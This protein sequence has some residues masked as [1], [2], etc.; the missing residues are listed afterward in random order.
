[1]DNKKILIYAEL[2]Q[3]E[4]QP[5][6]LELMTKARDLF[7]AED[8]QIAYVTC[9]SDVKGAVKELSKMGADKVYYAQ[10]EKLS[11][12]NV[13]YYSAVI[14]AVIDEFHPDIVLIPAS[15][16]G[17][18][19]SPTISVQCMTAGAAHCV[20]LKV[21]ED[22]QFVTMVPAFGGK[23][24]GEIMI[25]KTRP[26]IASIKPGI[27]GAK[28]QPE[29][30]CEIKELDHSV[31]DGVDSKIKVRNVHREEPKGIPVENAEIVVCGGDGMGSKENYDRLAVLA[32]KLGGAVGCTRPVLDEGWEKDEGKLIG[33][34]GKGI[35]PK[36]YIGF[37]ISGS[38]HH[39]CGMTDS[40]KVISVNISTTAPIFDSSDYYVVKDGPAVVEALISK[41]S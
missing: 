26:Q 22:G 39:L 29:R 13:D 35:R 16:Y 31:V 9:G 36:I 27:F 12:F 5:S 24:I 20:D 23:V 8:E 25:P 37:G 1:M 30:E 28:E 41:L 21:A 7:D 4:V 15:T 33:T 40:G 2:E 11:I 32:E 10:S 38:S 18:E 3:N 34:S 6:A 17:E 14:K 19:L